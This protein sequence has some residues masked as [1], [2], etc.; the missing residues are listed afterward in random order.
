MYL[1]QFPAPLSL[2]AGH[3]SH[4]MI[5]TGE[6]TVGLVQSLARLQEI[7]HTEILSRILRQLGTEA[8]GRWR[9][10]PDSPSTG[11]ETGVLPTAPDTVRPVSHV[12]P[13]AELREAGDELLLVAGE[14]GA[15]LAGHG[16]GGRG[17]DGGGGGAVLSF[18]PGETEV[19]V[20][21]DTVREEPALLPVSERGLEPESVGLTAG[22]V[23]TELLALGLSLNSVDLLQEAGGLAGELTPAPVISKAGAQCQ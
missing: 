1:T 6:D 3:I 23:G 14:G 4:R 9:D 12:L 16:G 15:V 22:T 21:G 10:V 19:T 8:A 2:P 17:G 13:W 18:Y 11:V 5:V 20:S 7:W